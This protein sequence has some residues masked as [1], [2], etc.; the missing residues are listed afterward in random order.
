M[1]RCHY[2]KLYP[3]KDLPDKRQPRRRSSSR[4]GSVIPL[5]AFPPGAE[6]L[7]IVFAVA[8]GTV[9]KTFQDPKVNPSFYDLPSGMSQQDVPPHVLRL[10]IKGSSNPKDIE[11]RGK[12]EPL[13]LTK[14]VYSKRRPSDRRQEPEGPSLGR[15]V[16]T[17]EVTD[18]LPLAVDTTDGGVCPDIVGFYCRLETADIDTDFLTIAADLTIQTYIA[19]L[20][21][22]MGFA[23][24]AP[25]ATRYRKFFM[26]LDLETNPALLEERKDEGL[27]AP[28]VYD[29]RYL[30]ITH[31][32]DVLRHRVQMRWTA[33]TTGAHPPTPA[34]F[35][36]PDIYLQAYTELMSKVQFD[37]ARSY[38]SVDVGGSIDLN[39]VE[40]AFEMFANGELRT[41]LPSLYWTTQPSSSFYLYF[42]EFAFLALECFKTAGS[43]IS[44]EESV[45]WE[46]VLSCLIR[47]QE[48]YFR[49][50][51]PPST[52]PLKFTDYRACNYSPL[53]AYACS[54][55]HSLRVR[56]E[57]LPLAG[58]RINTLA[59]RMSRNLLNAMPGGV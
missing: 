41:Q 24:A 31:L 57:S 4:F 32:F 27:I 45:F 18:M 37:V 21:A 6:F 38:L 13:E 1:P 9:D 56:Y 8:R 5:P 55:K 52:A 30:A 33:A 3:A 12:F 40:E 15:E 47:T 14:L 42:A 50:Y 35:G 7:D 49:V 23:P 17:D 59:L 39:F 28:E 20:T 2:T 53:D 43:K 46:K 16:G 19:Q 10:F 34:Q 48:I 29:T 58:D 44:S 11:V 51:C 22:E 26:N 36:L 25:V 54:E